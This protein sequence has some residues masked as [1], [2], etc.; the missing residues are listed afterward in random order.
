MLGFRTADSPAH[1]AS[2]EEPA[3]GLLADQGAPRVTL[4]DRGTP[5][6]GVGAPQPHLAP[7]PELQVTG[8]ALVVGCVSSQAE[9]SHLRTSVSAS[10]NTIGHLDSG[11]LRPLSVPPLAVKNP[12]HINN[13]PSSP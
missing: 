2:Q 1:D 12:A 3:G 8:G 9:N 6:G 10:K 4:G 7:D 5:S 13:I 11:S